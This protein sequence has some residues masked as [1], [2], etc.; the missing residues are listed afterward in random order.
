MG[1]LPCQTDA[2]VLS[3]QP[4][5]SVTIDTVSHEGLL[6]DQGSDPVAFFAA[7]G[8]AACDVLDDAVA[9]AASRRRNTQTD[10][11]HIVTG[12]IRVEGAAPG[13]LLKITVVR[14]QPRAAYGVISNR[15]GRGPWLESFR[16][17]PPL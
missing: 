11:P 7:H 14:L 17:A 15:H 6:E 3:I 12:P 9:I 16:A 1:T 10:G 5:E 13:D 4:G 2:P 8:V